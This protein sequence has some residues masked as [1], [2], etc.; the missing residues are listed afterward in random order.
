[1]SKIRVLSV[2][3]SALMRQIMTEIINSHSDMEMVATAPDPLVARDLI[4]KFNPDV[5]TLDVEMPRMD[6]LD[7]LEKL[8]RLRPMP[9]VMVSSLTGKGSE[10]TLRALELGAIDFVTKPQLGIREG[11]LAYSEMIAE[12]VR[13]AA[14]AS[15]ADK[16]LS[17][18]TTLKAGPLLSSE[19]LIAIGASTGGTEAIRHVLQPL[20]LSSPALLITQHMPPGFTRSFADRL[21]KLCQIGVKE[22]EDGERVLPGHAYIAPGDRHMELSRSGAN[23]QIKIHDGPAVNRHRPSVDVLFHSVAK[24]AGRNA[25]GVILTGM[26]NDGAAGMLAMRQAGAWTLAQ[27]EA[28]CVVF[29]MPREAINMGGVCEVVDLSQVSQQM[30]AKIS[31]GQAI[32]I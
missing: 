11:M 10:V 8:M 9:V 32:R 5:L 2:D 24:Q 23:Y 15:L 13:T 30:L 1:M 6:G 20:P 17:A 31:A 21:N 22:A 18:P 25:V 29:G 28:S 14:K 26:G 12:K 16:P 4:K 27:N 19:K 3:D 7:F